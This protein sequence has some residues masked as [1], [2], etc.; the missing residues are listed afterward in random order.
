[1]HFYQKN[2][3]DFNNATRHLTRVERSLF[4]DAIELY[5]DTEKPLIG[6]FNRLS[7]LLLANS[8]EE[9]EALKAV[10]SEFFT[11]TDEGYFNKRCNE[12]ILKYQEYIENKVKAG[13]ASAEQRQKKDSTPAEQPTNK[14]ST[15]EQLTNNQY[16]IPINQEPLP[17]KEFN[18]LNS[19]T[20]SSEVDEIFLFWQARL[21]HPQAKL[22]Q[23]RKK[24]IE[25]V[26]KTGYTVTQLKLAITGLSIS[27]FHIDQG[28]DDITYAFR[29][30]NIDKFIADANTP[31]HERRRKSNVVDFVN[32][33]F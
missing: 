15:G 5:Y 6:D 32:T 26:L 19:K 28:Y 16:P 17:K 13:K 25:K 24:A 9:K 2:I 18:K 22:T 29:G 14:C 27:E 33:G 8:D 11:L 23:E 10:L 20:L 7:R 3:P 30:T 1:M 12:E 4:S 21:R 31:E